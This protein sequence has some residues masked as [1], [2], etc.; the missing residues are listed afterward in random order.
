M[1]HSKNKKRIKQ[2]KKK[3][4][5]VIILFHYKDLPVVHFCIKGCLKNLNCRNIY[6]IS[7]AVNKRFFEKY[8]QVEFIEEDSF[9][10]GLTRERIINLWQQK[11]K[12]Y[13]DK[14]ALWFYQQLL[15][16][17]VCYRIKNLSS[18]YLL[19]DSDVVFLR[20]A[21]MIDKKRSLMSISSEYHRPY[22]KM[23]K[24]ILKFHPYRQY[25]FIAHHQMISKNIMRQ[26]LK[27]ISGK[28]AWRNHWYQQ[29]IDNYD[30]KEKNGFSEYETYGHFLKEFYPQFFK[31]RFLKWSNSTKI[32]D[33]KFLKKLRNKYDFVCFHTSW[34]QRERWFLRWVKK[35]AAILFK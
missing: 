13:V 28:K 21:T 2:H 31:L 20:P 32:P 25:S 11:N 8:D 17:A 22:F 3:P 14:S 7:N 34:R 18:H 26:M 33:K 23:M 12:K 24:R 6:V 29:I 35:V 30:F 4:Y 5:D 27:K 1:A 10:P 19:L 9:I 16:M 15:K